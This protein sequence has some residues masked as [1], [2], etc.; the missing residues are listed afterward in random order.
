MVLNTHICSMV[1]Q[2]EGVGGEKVGGR[3]EGKEGIRV[4]SRGGRGEEGRRTE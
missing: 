4:G 2:T 3:E 1:F